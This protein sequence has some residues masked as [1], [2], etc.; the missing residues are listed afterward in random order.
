M[1]A[2]YYLGGAFKT[3]RFVANFQAAPIALQCSTSLQHAGRWHIVSRKKQ[4]TE[5]R[6]ERAKISCRYHFDA[7]TS[8]KRLKTS[9]DSPTKWVEPFQLH[10]LPVTVMHIA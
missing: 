1:Q 3:G 8:M 9:S 5:L 10:H 2:K 4:C 6:T 7:A